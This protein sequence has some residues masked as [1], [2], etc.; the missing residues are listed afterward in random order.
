MTIERIKELMS[1]ELHDAP[2]LSSEIWDYL[3]YSRHTTLK[4]FLEKSA[5][6][7][8][9]AYSRGIVKERTC[10][11][12]SISRE[13][14]VELVKKRKPEDAAIVNGFFYE[15]IGKWM[16]KEMLNFQNYG[17]K[18]DTPKGVKVFQKVKGHFYSFSL[19]TL[20]LSRC[21]GLCPYSVFKHC[22]QNIV[23]KYNAGNPRFENSY[24]T[25]KKEPIPYIHF[26]DLLHENRY[27]FFILAEEI[28]NSF[29]LNEDQRQRLIL[30][31]T[32]LHELLLRQIDYD[33]KAGRRVIVPPQDKKNHK[34]LNR[35]YKEAAKKCHPDK[36]QTEDDKQKAHQLF[37]QLN[38]AYSKNDYVALKKITKSLAV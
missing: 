34:D 17:K 7:I 21:V 19:S 14:F 1:E 31:K 22:A 13:L 24:Y 30:F 8:D 26:D 28:L 33:L 27:V 35:I 15:Y 10:D 23:E 5:L 18:G 25:R 16:R 9:I 29:S 36:F 38:D 12:Y 11:A 32:I 3:N 37:V 4:R 2:F 20:N 6:Q